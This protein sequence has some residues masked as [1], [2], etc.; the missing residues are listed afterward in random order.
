M[1]SSLNKLLKNF[2]KKVQEKLNS[3][4]VHFNII[5]SIFPEAARLSEKV[6]ND[7]RFKLSAP[8]DEGIYNFQFQSLLK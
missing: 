2:Q 5:L 3:T 1:K 6:E 4:Y 8:L 7:I